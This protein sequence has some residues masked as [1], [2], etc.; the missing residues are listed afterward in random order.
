[1]KNFC[2]RLKYLLGEIILHTQRFLIN[3]NQLKDAI[4]LELDDIHQITD[5]IL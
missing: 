3:E 5:K 4:I 1:M 2:W